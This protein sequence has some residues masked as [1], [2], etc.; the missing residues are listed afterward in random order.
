MVVPSEDGSEGVSCLGLRALGGWF[1][2]P[3][4]AWTGIGLRRSRIWHYGA[5]QWASAASSE[6]GLAVCIGGMVFRFGS[7][8]AVS[9]RGSSEHE[10][11]H[12][13]TL[14][15]CGCWSMG[16]CAIIDSPSRGVLCLAHGWKGGDE[17]RR[18]PNKSWWFLASG[19]RR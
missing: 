6:R 13:M 17:A 2:V 5:V 12:H 15:Q 19:C 16:G 4:S 9:H 10:R 11:C 3:D 1:D 8:G 7:V 18:Y 14:S